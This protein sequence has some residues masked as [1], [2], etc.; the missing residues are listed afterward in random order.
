M[1]YA[2]DRP[3]ALLVAVV[4]LLGGTLFYAGALALIAPR[5]V[6]RS[7]LRYARTALFRA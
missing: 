5:A 2:T 1:P 3:T 7:S 4:G 6:V